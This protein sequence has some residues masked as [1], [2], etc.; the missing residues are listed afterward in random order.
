MAQAAPT[1]F[2]PFASAGGFTVVASGD[3]VLGN[4]E[5]EGSVAAGGSLST[6]SSNYPLLHDAAGSAAYTVPVIDGV[7]V[8]ILAGRLSGTGTF[9][10][11]NRSDSRGIA[12]DSPEAKAQARFV[13]VTGLT[14][15]AGNG[16][17]RVTATTGGALDLKSVPAST[18]VSALAT[19]RDSVAAYVTAGEA[20]STQCLATMYDSDRVHTVDVDDRW[21]MLYPTFRTDMPNVLDYADLVGQWGPKTIK[22]DN[23]AGYAP[24]ATAPLVIRVPAG[25]TKIGQIQVEGWSAHRSAQQHYAQHILLDLSAVTG[26]VTIDGLE[27]GAIYAPHADVVFSS[28]V[29]L[30]TQIVAKSFRSS[31]G[32]ELHHYAFRGVL[33]C[34]AA[35]VEQPA[36]PEPGDGEPGDVDGEPGGETSGE[37]EPGAGTPGEGESG[38]GEPGVG[39]PGDAESGELTPGAGEPGA[40]ESGAGESG[41]GESEPGAGTP[42]EG[43]SADGEPEKE[44]PGAGE[45]AET[46]PGAGESR[47][48]APEQGGSGTIGDGGPG[49]T[50]PGA[51]ESGDTE[52][53]DGESESGDVSPG[54]GGV[55]PI[56]PGCMMPEENEPSDGSSDDDSLGGGAPGTGEPG[57]GESGGDAPGDGEPVTG[58]PEPGDGESGDLT[59]GQEGSETIEAGGDGAG[60]APGDGATGGDPSGEDA[61]D[62]GPGD[63]ESSGEDAPGVD[64]PEGLDSDGVVSG[65][66]PEDADSD[67]IVSGSQPGEE[68]VA[69]SAH[70]P[71]SDALALTGGTLPLAAAGA[72]LAL[73]VI[74]G[75]ALLASRR[76]SR[77]N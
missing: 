73:M 29:T 69:V 8:R 49:D 28:G 17:L 41:A 19:K 9:D 7:P 2:N 4:G 32:G 1:T 58:E 25:T 12:A 23:A 59:P 67:G 56:G 45:P 61:S 13:D 34:A 48:T 24:T 54:E 35:E 10:L 27:M 53:G 74:G 42:G 5:L 33:P 51:G 52:P 15:S 11:S 60:D 31:G 21:G 6:T 68:D 66:E 71:K 50:E 64:T 22:M 43:E 55:S 37:A 38:D 3:V 72:A 77:M 70:T 36:S 62:G 16:F 76:R 57:D 44:T 46:E 14:G 26:T 63:G 65:Q 75:V 39:T 40:G 30:N 47:P 20:A 18:P